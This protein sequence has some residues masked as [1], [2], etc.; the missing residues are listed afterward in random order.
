WSKAQER[1]SQ[2]AGRASRWTTWPIPP[3][4]TPTRPITCGLGMS[5]PLRQNLLRTRSIRFTP[6]CTMQSRSKMWRLVKHYA[7]NRTRPGSSSRFKWRGG[8]GQCGDYA[9]VAEWLRR[10]TSLRR[11]GTATDLPGPPSGGLR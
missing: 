4:S 7:A 1:R 10:R 6:G 2:T 5:R 3:C 8:E 11:C 9:T